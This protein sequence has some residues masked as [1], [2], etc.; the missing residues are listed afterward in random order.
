METWY[1]GRWSPSLL[2]DYCWTAIRDTTSIDYKKQTKI[3][4]AVIE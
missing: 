2:A 4:Q 3:N 1:Q